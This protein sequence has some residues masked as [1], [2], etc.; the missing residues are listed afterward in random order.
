[1][2]LTALFMVVMVGMT[3][4]VVDVGSWFRAQ[5]ATQSTVDAAALAGRSGAPGRS[6][7]SVRP[8]SRLRG[9]ERRRGRRRRTSPSQSKYA[10]ERHDPNLDDEVRARLLLVGLRTRQRHRRSARL[11]DRRRPVRG[12]VRRSDRRQHPAPGSLW[13]RLP[14]LRPGAPDQPAARQDGCARRVRSPEPESGPDERHGRREHTRRLDP[15]RLLEVPAAR[16]L[17]LR[18]GREVQRQPVPGCPRRAHRHRPSL[19][20]LRHADRRRARMPPTT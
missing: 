4:F 6:D 9:E 13:A 3:A 2:V 1:M 16:W 11:C 12:G 8:R 15:E 19:P 10:A 18:S 20:R 7:H 14:L 17:L 5:R